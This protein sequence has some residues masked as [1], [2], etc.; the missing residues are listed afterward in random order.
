MLDERAEGDPLEG[1]RIMLSG[2]AEEAKGADLEIMRRRYLN[3][4]PSAEAFVNFAGFFLLPDPAER[5]PSGGRFR[6]NRRSEARAVP[7]RYF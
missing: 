5:H 1:A 2:R 4:H 3:A 7:D 6:A